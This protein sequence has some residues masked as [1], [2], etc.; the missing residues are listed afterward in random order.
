[1]RRQPP[2]P[3]EAGGQDSFVDVVTNLVGILIVLV[4]IVGVRVKPAWRASQAASGQ[5]ASADPAVAANAAD[6]A[7]SA[8]AK[9]L[10]SLKATADGIERDVRQVASQVASVDGELAQRSAER[11]KVATL[12]ASAEHQIDDRSSKLDSGAR[13]EFELKRQAS[14]L[15]S[16]LQESQTEL[17]RAKNA[18]PPVAELKHYMTPISRTVFGK[19]VHFRLCDHR[20]AYLPL[21]ELAER[22]KTEIHSEGSSS[23][24]LTDHI[25]VVGPFGG[26]TMEFTMTMEPGPERGQYAISLKESRFLPVPGQIG[27]TTDEALGPD[28]EFRRHLNSLDRQQTTVTIWV[29]P[30]SFAD[31]RRINDELYRLGFGIAA[32]PLPVGVPVGM[33]SH[34]T[35]SAAE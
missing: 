25:H 23:T 6:D 34:G 19:E 20:I 4:L 31:Y 30:E 27:E 2:E 29:Y 15:E 14:G 13:E 22:A 8:A 10:T 28:S 5:S 16:E 21:E 3:I 17:Q 18:P 24:D 12:I 9:E 35:R 11:E 32:R 33:S 7:K 26:F 1:M